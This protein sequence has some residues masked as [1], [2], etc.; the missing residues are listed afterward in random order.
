MTISEQS[1]YAILDVPI[2]APGHCFT[3]GTA[4]NEDGRKFIDFG[5]QIDWFGA[6]Y[7]CSEC[8]IE[9]A[10]IVGFL[11]VA[12]FNDLF[13]VNKKLQIELDQANKRLE[14]LRNIYG[15]LFAGR[16]DVPSSLDDVSSTDS[17]DATSVDE[18]LR[19]DVSGDSDSEQTPSVEG[20]SD[21][22]DVEDFDDTKSK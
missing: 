10:A 14:N 22:F 1:R 15:D 2:L 3:C 7:L 6:V 8:I 19:A 20:S 5:K 11:P 21:F 12:K 16:H 17:V 13:D 4:S 9:V 18:V